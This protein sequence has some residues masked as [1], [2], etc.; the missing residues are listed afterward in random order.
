MISSEMRRHVVTY[1]V[2]ES[3]E[4]CKVNHL[5]GEVHGTRLRKALGHLH[6]L[7]FEGYWIFV[8]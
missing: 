8:R 4:E 3:L 6:A 5:K 2:M 7:K 1:L